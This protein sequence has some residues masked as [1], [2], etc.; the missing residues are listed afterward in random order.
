MRLKQHT[1]KL[2]LILIA[3]TDSSAAGRAQNPTALDSIPSVAD[4][5]YVHVK[6]A[7]CLEISCV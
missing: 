4:M 3:L 1:T 5:T 2:N 7:M 6:T